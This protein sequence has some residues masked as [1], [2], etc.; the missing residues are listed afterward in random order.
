[1][2][3]KLLI[4]IVTLNS[5][6]SQFL[7]KRAV[8]EIGAPSSLESWPQFF[9]AAALSPP[10]YGSLILQVIG[11]AIWMVVI[12]QEKLGVAVAILGSGFYVLMALLAWL[13]FDEQL[14]RLQ[15]T[16]IV[17]ITIGVA[18]MMTTT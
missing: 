5:V 18:C 4:I 12:S 13:M 3:A 10:V 17:L 6:A 1:M 2:S 9:K 14:T 16:G 8:N 11:Y 7:L 15:W